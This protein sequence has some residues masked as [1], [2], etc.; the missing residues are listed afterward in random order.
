MPTSTARSWIEPPDVGAFGR[1]RR[2]PPPPE[3]SGRDAARHI[4]RGF[5]RGRPHSQDLARLPPHSTLVR[6]ASGSLRKLDAVTKISDSI[7]ASSGSA[8]GRSFAA[9]R[10]APRL[11]VCVPT[12]H[13]SLPRAL[14]GRGRLAGYV[15]TPSAGRSLIFQV[16]A[17]VVRSTPTPHRSSTRR[18]CRVTPTRPRSA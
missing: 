4:A 9:A 5:R 13:R 18:R 11:D 17:R 2:T 7:W 1:S 14:E 8:V 16:T 6:P 3:E 15:G 10:A 12:A